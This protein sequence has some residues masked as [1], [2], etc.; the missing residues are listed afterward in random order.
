M[1]LRDE[2]DVIDDVMLALSEIAP[3]SEGDDSPRALPSNDGNTRGG[4]NR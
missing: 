1:T 3:K 2:D 4:E